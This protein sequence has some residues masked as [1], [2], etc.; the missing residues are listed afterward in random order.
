MSKGK[1]NVS[2]LNSIEVIDGAVGIR[3]GEGRVRV[4]VKPRPESTPAAILY[5]PDGSLAGGLTFT[6]DGSLIVSLTDSEGEPHASVVL[7]GGAPFVV[8]FPPD[9]EPVPVHIPP[10]HDFL[11]HQN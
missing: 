6:P 8:H 10:A 9:A 11:I 1:L 4:I 5:R 7:Y 3:D 2:Q